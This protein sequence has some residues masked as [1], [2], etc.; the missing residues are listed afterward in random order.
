MQ[1]LLCLSCLYH[2][3][4]RNKLLLHCHKWKWK[5][6]DFSLNVSFSLSVLQRMD[7]WSVA[8][9][10]GLI[11]IRS[12]WF[13]QRDMDASASNSFCCHSFVFFTFVM[14]Q[15]VRHYVSL[16]LFF[17]CFVLLFAFIFTLDVF[18]GEIDLHLV[19]LAF[20]STKG[21]DP[22]LVFSFLYIIYA[23]SEAI[24]GQRMCAPSFWPHPASSW[25][26]D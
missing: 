11:V 7:F 21:K 22:Y 8:G 20:L 25:F 12:C 16:F 10:P 3:G 19:R 14:K 13:G 18:M 23:H 15:Y 1:N 26:W 24:Q 4:I 2:F 17:L 9:R 6:H 5:S